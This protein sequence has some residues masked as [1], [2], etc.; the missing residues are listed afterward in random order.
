MNNE[1]G[2]LHLGDI[3]YVLEAFS[4]K[5]RWDGAKHGPHYVLKTRV[6]SQQD[7]ARKRRILGG[8]HARRPRS[9]RPPQHDD[10]LRLVLEGLN[11][12]LEHELGINL[13]KF[14]RNLLRLVD[15]VARELHCHHGAPEGDADL[16]EQ[17]VG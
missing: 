13:N 11:E 16:E 10:V 3:L 4:D 8:D 17:V 2:A 1:R 9:H 6:G 7:Q 12:K 5:H 15:S 14:C